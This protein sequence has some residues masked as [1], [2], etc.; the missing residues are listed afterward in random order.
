M[1]TALNQTTD[2]LAANNDLT[3]IFGANEP[4]AIGMGRAI[5]QAGKAGQLVAIGFDGNADLQDMVKS[6]TLLATAVQGS[7]QMGELGV[8]AVADILAGTPVTDFIDTG[9][10]MVTKENINTPVAQNV[11]Y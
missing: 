4:T 8:N 6:G 1:A 11:L 3:G 10:V 2:L 9:V 7:F 5:E